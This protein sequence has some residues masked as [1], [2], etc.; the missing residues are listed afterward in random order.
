MIDRVTA[1]QC[2]LCDACIA[3]CPTEAISKGNQIR[4]FFYPRIDTDK[5]IS[6]NLCEKVCPALAEVLPEDKVDSSAWVVWNKEESKRKSSTSGGT[7][8]ALAENFLAHG[9]YVCGAALDENFR[10]RHILSNRPEDVRE[11]MGSKYVQSDMAGVYPQIKELLK[12]GTPVLFSGCPCQVAALHSFLGKEYKTLFCAEVVCH[13]IPS[14]HLWEQYL[15]LREEIHGGKVQSVEFRSKK[16]GWHESAVRLTFDNGKEYLEPYYRDAFAGAMVKNITLK[17]S[18]YQCSFKNFGSGADITLGDFWGA[19]VE[20]PELDDNKGL[21]AVMAHT[22]QAVYVL[23]ELG[24]NMVSYEL[25][26]FVKY[27]K[28]IV[29]PAPKSPVREA[30]YCTAADQGYACAIRKHLMES[31]KDKALRKLKGYLRKMKNGVMSMVKGKM[32]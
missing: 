10:V 29:C 11:M 23:R 16:M 6:C 31:S 27:N 5:C 3:A 17:E 2:V 22:P 13:G 28:S 30:F 9:G 14:A 26:R 8:I 19:N 1:Q 7:F 32:K 25:E 21:S 4:D 20:M 18:C 24:L 12:N 15:R